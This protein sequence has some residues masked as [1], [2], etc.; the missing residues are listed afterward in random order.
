MSALSALSPPL[1]FFH[2]DE[3]PD[4]Y[5]ITGVGTCMEPEIADGSVVAFTKQ[6]P[7]KPGDVVSIV[8]TR[9]AGRRRG[10]P[11]LIKRLV[12]PP[13]F[14]GLVIVE[15]FNPP[16][17]YT[18]P[19]TDILAIHKLIGIAQSAGDGQALIER[20]LLDRAGAAP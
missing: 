15:Q 1:P 9:E 7:P 8:F 13:G 5:A 16:R 14:E 20:S 19:T 3:M 12:I 2:P 18:I 4:V 17:T 6:V 10:L 11:G